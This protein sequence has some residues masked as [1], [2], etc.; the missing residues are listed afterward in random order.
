M[1]LFDQFKTVSD[2]MKNMKPEEM[3]KLME[4]AQESQKMLADQIRKIIKEE[5][6][7]QGLVSREEVERMIRDSK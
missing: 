1:G 4:Q 6:E 2:M 5:I 7:S 3:G